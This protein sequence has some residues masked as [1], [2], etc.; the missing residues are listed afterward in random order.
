[1]IVR[2]IEIYFFVFILFIVSSCKSTSTKDDSKSQIPISVLDTLSRMNYLFDKKVIHIKHDPRKKL[3]ALTIICTVDKNNNFYFLG[4]K[5]EIYKFSQSGKLTKELSSIGRGPGE[6]NS[7][8]SMI[9][10][11]QFNLYMADYTGQK[12]IKYDSSFN[13]VMSFDSHTSQGISRMAFDENNHLV[14]YANME[15]GK[16]IFIFDKDTGKLIS[17]YGKG[18]DLLEIYVYRSGWNVN[19]K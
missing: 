17:R 14:C 1:M 18:I 7:V 6:Y 13:Y 3:D 11:D 19:S 15:Q 8:S 9:C 4:M 16:P 5:E 10:D 12:I 2:N